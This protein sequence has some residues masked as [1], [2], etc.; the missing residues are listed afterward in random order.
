MKYIMSKIFVAATVLVTTLSGCGESERL[1]YYS[2]DYELVHL[3]QKKQQEKVSVEEIISLDCEHCY[4]FV[5][6]VN[7]ELLKQ[8]GERLEIQPIPL[9]FNKQTQFPVRL[10]IV[11]QK[12]GKEKD[13]LEYM[14]KKRF[15]ENKNIFDE[16]VVLD[17]A[18]N[19]GL[20]EQYQA[21]KDSEWVEKIYQD[22]RSKGMQYGIS[23]TPTL[24]IEKQIK[25]TNINVDNVKGIIDDLLK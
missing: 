1:R 25:V 10:F 14:L 2:G 21:D 19:F 22:N 3:I 13:V 23:Q 5:V 12:S 9:V 15:V 24:I 8:Y 20:K 7:H 16:N 18:S 6:N 17:I 4:K 11:S